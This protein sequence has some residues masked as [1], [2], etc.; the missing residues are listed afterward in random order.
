MIRA[1]GRR[2]LDGIVK[3]GIG[4]IGVVVWVVIALVTAD[5]LGWTGIFWGA[6]AGGALV[7]GLSTLYED[8][9]G[10]PLS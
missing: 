8:A 4:T 3:V 7:T 1:V 5:L 6:I 2:L 9:I 10:R